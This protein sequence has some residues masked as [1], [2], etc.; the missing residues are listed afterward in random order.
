MVR[1]D[2]AAVNLPHEYYPAIGEF[3]FRYA[4]L[5]YLLNEI[6]WRCMDIDNKQGRVLTIG[7]DISVLIGTINTVLGTPRWVQ[8]NHIKGEAGNILKVVKDNK[9]LRNQLAHGSWQFPK[10]GS[11]ANV[12]MHYM[13]EADDRIVPTAKRLTPETLH[14]ASGKLKA[15]IE[16][17]KRLI[18]EIERARPP[19]APSQ[20]V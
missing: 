6:V 10:N 19:R 17:A 3:V 1:I 11:P 4:Q 9:A 5:E 20:P 18:L 13:K 15:T 2:E 16:R 12:F 14:K 8:S 7:S